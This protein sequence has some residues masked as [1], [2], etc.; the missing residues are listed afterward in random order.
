[1]KNDLKTVIRLLLKDRS[2]FLINLAGLAIGIASFL[3][4]LHFVLHHMSFDRNIESGERLV[5]IIGHY[6][7]NG[8]DRGVGTLLPGELA[9]TLEENL[10]YVEKSTRFYSIS[11]NNNSIIYKKDDATV[12][13]SES[14]V[15]LVDQPAF[16]LF[17]WRFKYGSEDRFDEWRI[18]REWRQ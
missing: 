3:V 5:R 15:Y 1:M 2:F 17:D 11:Y 4:I 6:T 16:D 8:E 9:P 12:S 10:T 18:W 14:D 13:Y 7:Q